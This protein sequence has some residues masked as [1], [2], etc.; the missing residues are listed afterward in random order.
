[1]YAAR[2]CCGLSSTSNCHQFIIIHLQIY[3][4]VTR[5]FPTFHGSKQRSLAYGSSSPAWRSQNAEN[6]TAKA[7]QCRR[8]FRFVPNVILLLQHQSSFR[9]MFW[10][11]KECG[12]ELQWSRSFYGERNHHQHQPAIS[13]FHFLKNIWKLLEFADLVPFQNKVI[14]TKSTLTFSLVMCQISSPV[15]QWPQHVRPSLSQTSSPTM[16]MLTL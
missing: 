6:A 14:V 13:T 2:R 5:C 7:R 9:S 8:S 12:G 4:Y 11:T 1:M 3:I 10:N 16:L 15:M